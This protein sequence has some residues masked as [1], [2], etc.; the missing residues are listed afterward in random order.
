M[1]VTYQQA[2]GQLAGGQTV[3]FTSRPE[4]EDEEAEEE[5]RLIFSV[6]SLHADCVCDI[7]RNAAL[8]LVRLGTVDG[9]Q[10]VFGL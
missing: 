7:T 3:T 1:C 5:S 2:H 9:L 8:S 6:S 4:G 10:C